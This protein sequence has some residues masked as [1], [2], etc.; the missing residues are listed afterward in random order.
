MRLIHSKN[1]QRCL[2][3]LW[4]LSFI[5]TPACDPRMSSDFNNH[6]FGF[7]LIPPSCSPASS[8]SYAQKVEQDDR[9]GSD[10]G[11]HAQQRRFD[12]E[13]GKHGDENEQHETQKRHLVI[14]AVWRHSPWGRGV[15][16]RRW[17]HL[18]DVTCDIWYFLRQNL[19]R[20]RRLCVKLEHIFK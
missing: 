7:T 12:K 14:S 5:H 15:H 4:T 10:A 16:G 18:C 19:L 11:D 13:A 3:S 17:R 8:Y 6:L 20:W 9:A 2:G 1:C